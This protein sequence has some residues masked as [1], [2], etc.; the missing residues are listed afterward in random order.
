[1][2]QV[3]S[4]GVSGGKAKF[5]I[6]L[7]RHSL[8][9]TTKLQ[10][11]EA[12]LPPE[13]SIELPNVHVTAEYI[14][15]SSSSQETQF[16]DGVILRQGAYLN[17]IADIGDFERSLTTDLLNHLVF[18]QKVFMKEVNEVVQKVYGGEKPVPLWLDD[19]DE[20]TQPSSLKRLLFSLVIR[21]KRIQLTATTPT[22]CAV[23]LETGAVELQLSNRVENVSGGAQPWPHSR[24]HG[25]AQVDI[26]L[27][28]GQL[29][30]NVIFEEA[31]PEFQQYAFFRTRIGRLT[32]LK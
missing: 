18:V 16:A 13:A 25:N 6:D 23:R 2:D 5:T 20:E 21:I 28:L 14:Q 32:F 19:A 26:N 17:A 29:I 1:M 4:T 12:N 9:F 22:N 24:I 11:S 15:D 30:K 8:S 27:S 31:D 7:P 10:T 3:S